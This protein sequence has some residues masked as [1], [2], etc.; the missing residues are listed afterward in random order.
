L[1]TLTKHAKV[2]MRI[3]GVAFDDVKT[4][5]SRPTETLATRANRLASYAEIQGR[6]IVVIHERHMDKDVVVTVMSV[7]RRRLARF[8]FSKI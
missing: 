7:D 2:Q 4:V 5:L 6:Y 3:R 1:I 8:G